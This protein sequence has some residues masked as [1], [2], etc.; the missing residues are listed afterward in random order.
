MKK[1]KI[2]K[3]VFFQSVFSFYE[4]MGIY[5]PQPD[6]TSFFNLKIVLVLLSL[7]LAFI[8]TS[9]FFLFEADSIIEHIETFYAALTT[10]CCAALMLINRSK[11]EKLLLLKQIA[12]ELIEK[13]ECF[14]TFSNI[15]WYVSLFTNFWILYCWIIIKMI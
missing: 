12:E 8:S 4:T 14:F 2:K 6:A 5:T 3:I 11:I 7:I 1:K 10:L 13:S 9:V 15:S